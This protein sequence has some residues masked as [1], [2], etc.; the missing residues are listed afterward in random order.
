MSIVIRFTHDLS[1]YFSTIITPFVV[2]MFY[3]FNNRQKVPKI[4][5]NQ[6]LVLE[7]FF[8]Q[9]FVPTVFLNP[10]RINKKGKTSN[11]KEELKYVAFFTGKV[12]RLLPELAHRL[13]AIANR[14]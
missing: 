7:T 12:G 2:N 14:S 1:I 10:G 3:L 8:N 4:D 6:Y 9:T 13:W 11:F 5:R